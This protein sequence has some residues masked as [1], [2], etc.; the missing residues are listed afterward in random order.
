M[1]FSFTA[2]LPVPAAKQT[3]GLFKGLSAATSGTR[4]IKEMM[5]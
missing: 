3:D 2:A 1:L 4:Y 5:K